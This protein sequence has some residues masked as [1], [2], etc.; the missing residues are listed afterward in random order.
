MHEL[1][2]CQALLAQ[3]KEIAQTHGA[4][5]VTQI[6][7][8]VGPL[9]GVEP[10]QLV[11]AF[12]WARAGSC[13]AQAELT[14]EQTVVRVRCIECGAESACPANCLLCGE[15][16]GF[17]TQVISGDELRLLR[18]ELSSSEEQR[19]PPGRMN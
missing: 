1:S 8:A 10:S 2:I 5:G 12:Q 13:A 7:V 9:S 3:V 18:V 15:C 11:E 6:I 14:F 16:R 19:W 17:R 4:T